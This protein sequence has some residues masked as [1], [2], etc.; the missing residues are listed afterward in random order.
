MGQYDIVLMIVALKLS[1]LGWIQAVAPTH[2]ITLGLLFKFLV[3]QFPHLQ[4]EDDDRTCMDAAH[5]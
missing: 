2:C 1:Y 4:N 5:Q 3:P